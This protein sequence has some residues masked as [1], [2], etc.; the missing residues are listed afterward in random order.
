MVGLESRTAMPQWPCAR[1]NRPQNLLTLTKLWCFRQLKCF[2]LIP[3]NQRVQ[4]SALTNW[5]PSARKQRVTKLCF[6]IWCNLLCSVRCG[7]HRILRIAAK[8]TATINAALRRCNS[9]GPALLQYKCGTAYVCITNLYVAMRYRLVPE[10]E[11]TCYQTISQ[12]TTGFACMPAQQAHYLSYGILLLLGTFCFILRPQLELLLFLFKINQIPLIFQS[13][14]PPLP[15]FQ[16]KR[17]CNLEMLKY[18]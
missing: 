5:M 12:R 7:W 8:L 9:R 3:V 16:E 6:D 1:V 14:L 4:T 10:A 2:S 17:N 18:S 15:K 13:S 11:P